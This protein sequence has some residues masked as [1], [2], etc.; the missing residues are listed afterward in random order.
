MK[1]IRKWMIILIAGLMIL[2]LAGCG[3]T[4]T[5][6]GFDPDDYEIT[7]SGRWKDG[8]YT[9]TAAGKNGDI[10]VTVVIENG[11]MTKV[12]VSDHS[13]TPDKGGVAIEKLSE[14][15]IQDQSP[16]VDAVTGATV[17]SNAL[18][19]AVAECLQEASK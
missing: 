6:D 7:D 19:K 12:E 15:M 5:S 16:D 11:R 3:N 18:K 13:E 8:T 9:A 14:G 1:R 2:G 4:K 17:T 10:D